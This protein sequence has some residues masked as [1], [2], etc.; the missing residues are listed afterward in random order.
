MTF[1]KKFKKVAHY[2]ARHAKDVATLMSFVPGRVGEVA[3]AMQPAAGA[4]SSMASAIDRA[5]AR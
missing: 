5:N 2:G 1:W 3:K 4:M